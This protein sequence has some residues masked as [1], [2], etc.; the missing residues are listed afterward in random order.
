[1]IYLF[2]F[3]M[4]FSLK[5]FSETPF[6]AESLLLHFRQRPGWHLLWTCVPQMDA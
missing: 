4:Q 3:C 6:G 1:M 2:I 5:G